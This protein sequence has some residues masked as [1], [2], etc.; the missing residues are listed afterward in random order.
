MEA[1]GLER[2][3]KRKEGLGRWGGTTYKGSGEMGNYTDGSA[4][5]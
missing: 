3:G 2:E 4:I 5:A 1:V